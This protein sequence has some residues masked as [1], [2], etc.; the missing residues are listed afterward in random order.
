MANKTSMVKVTYMMYRY[1]T[2]SFEFDA[3][4]HEYLS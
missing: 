4:Q 2:N 3:I 1:D